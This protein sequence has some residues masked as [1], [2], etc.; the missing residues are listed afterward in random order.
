MDEPIEFVF[1]FRS[2]FAWL[3]AR[4]AL[5]MLH[6]ETKVRWCA[7]YPLPT[8][9]NF[10][11]PMI[12]AKARHNI[13]DLLRLAKAY[14]LRFGRPPLADPDWSIP[15]AAFLWG[16]REGKG[17]EIARALLDARWERGEHIETELSI[18]RAA[19]RVGL[20]PAAAIAASRDEKL[21][22]ALRDSVQRNYDERGI[23]GVPMFVL[24]DGT[25][26]W[27]HDR[28]EWAIANGYARG[29]S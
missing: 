3:A 1:S 29:A 26:F 27:G 21:R 2:P 28:M 8:F 10:D 19:E 11:R 13:E 18:G 4:H 25:R 5:P 14:G 22:G 12:P 23:F 20:D 6:P 17:P 9:P 24:S 16:D 7:F 15:H